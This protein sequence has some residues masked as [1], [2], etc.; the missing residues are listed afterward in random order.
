MSRN[1]STEFAEFVTSLGINHSKFLSDALSKR[2]SPKHFSII[3][4]YVYV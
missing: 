1:K 3:Y 2:N 4:F